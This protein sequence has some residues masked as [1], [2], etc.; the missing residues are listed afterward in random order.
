MLDAITVANS[1]SVPFVQRDC[2]VDPSGRFQE[3]WSSPRGPREKSDRTSLRGN[4]RGRRQSNSCRV[5]REQHEA[6]RRR[7][8]AGSHLQRFRQP[9]R[10]RSKSLC[11]RLPRHQRWVSFAAIAPGLSTRFSSGSPIN[12]YSRIYPEEMIQTG[13]STIDTMNSIARGQK[14]PIF[15]A[16]GLPH[17]EVAITLGYLCLSLTLTS[18]CCANC[19]SSRVGETSH[20]GCA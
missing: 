4:I 14:I 9:Y 8:H 3:R 2:A 17:N 13:I 15:S 5:Y 6:P 18:D 16:A 1:G 12:P 19:T 11:R 7:R 20:E 10:S